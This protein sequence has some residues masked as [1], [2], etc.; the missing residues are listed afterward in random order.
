M[1]FVTLAFSIH[2]TFVGFL[3]YVAGLQNT[4]DG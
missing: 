4:L 1:E 2:N 3:E